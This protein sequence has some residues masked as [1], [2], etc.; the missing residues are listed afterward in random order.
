MVSFICV[1][2]ICAILGISLGTLAKNKG[3]DY[4]RWFFM[5]IIPV[6]FPFAL[7]WIIFKKPEI[8]PE[9]RDENISK[10]KDSEFIRK[11]EE[12]DETHK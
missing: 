1:M 12:F 8:F 6:I 3:F 11:M 7:I 5:G 4:W 10:N 2:A 9:I